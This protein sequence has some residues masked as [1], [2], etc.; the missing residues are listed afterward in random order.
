[1]HEEMKENQNTIIPLPKGTHRFN[2][3]TTYIETTPMIYA[4]S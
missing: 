1:M 3:G 4:D 2:T